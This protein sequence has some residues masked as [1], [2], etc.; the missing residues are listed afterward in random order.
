MNVLRIEKYSGFRG[1]VRGKVKG[2]TSR[3]CLKKKPNLVAP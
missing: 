2:D 3:N 1:E